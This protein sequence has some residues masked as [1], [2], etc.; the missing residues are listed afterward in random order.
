MHPLSSFHP[1]SPGCGRPSGA[2]PESLGRVGTYGG[3]QAGARAVIPCLE[4][5][6]SI[7]KSPG[8]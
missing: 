5:A 2:M 4:C 3:S 7:S 1:S 8:S 6:A